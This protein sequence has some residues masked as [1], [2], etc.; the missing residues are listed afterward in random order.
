MRKYAAG[1]R[2]V[3][4]VGLATA[5]VIGLAAEA[6]ASG[7]Q[8]KE[9][10]AEG[11]GNAFAGSSAKAQDLSTIFYNPAGMTALSGH[12]AQ[13]VLSYI[14]PRAEFE[15][16][17]ATNSITGLSLAGSTSQSDAIDDA[18]LPAA[19]GMYSVSDTVEAWAGGK[20]TFWAG[21]RL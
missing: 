19:Y 2:L 15:A 16:D 5:T 7:F 9:Q 13:S 6:Q 11:L 14:M 10:S 12:Q 3:P 20:R 18:L 17:S 1:V 21:D 4:V 8:L